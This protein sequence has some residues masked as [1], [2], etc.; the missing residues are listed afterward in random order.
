MYIKFCTTPRNIENLSPHSDKAPNLA[1]PS[2]GPAPMIEKMN[3]RMD[4]IAWPILYT[5]S[6]L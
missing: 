4:K 5:Q 3:H 6:L 1:Q 2:K